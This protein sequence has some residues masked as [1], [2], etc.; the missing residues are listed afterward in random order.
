[1]DVAKSSIKT[2]TLLI[3]PLSICRC[4]CHGG[5]LCFKFIEFLG[6]LFL[7]LEKM[8][9]PDIGVQ[10]SLQGRGVITGDLSQC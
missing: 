9:S 5:T 7:L 6:N 3:E 4:V 10:N 1:V 8:L 2:F